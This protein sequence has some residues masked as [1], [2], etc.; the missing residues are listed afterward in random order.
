[1][2]EMINNQNNSVQTAQKTDVFFGAQKTKFTVSFH[3]YP[4]NLCYNVSGR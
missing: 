1:M 3:P 2:Y 4:E